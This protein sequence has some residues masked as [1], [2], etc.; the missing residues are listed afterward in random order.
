M[1]AVSTISVSFA[2]KNKKGAAV[3]TV[4]PYGCMVV[5]HRR[6]ELLFQE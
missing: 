1:N 4:A 6:I 3:F 2:F 5:A